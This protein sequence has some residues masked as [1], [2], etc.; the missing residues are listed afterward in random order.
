[1]HFIKAGDRITGCSS[2][3]GRAIAIECGRHGA[4]LVLHH[5]GDAQSKG[6][7]ETLRAELKG[8]RAAD[9]KAVLEADLAADVTDSEAG[10]LCVASLAQKARP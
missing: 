8:V 3:I 9:P 2:G 5:I 1:L 4:K 6:D 10:R 7:I